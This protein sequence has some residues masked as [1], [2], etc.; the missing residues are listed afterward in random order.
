MVVSARTRARKQN[1]PFT[2][3]EGDITIPAHCPVLGLELVRGVGQAGPASPSLDKIVPALGYVRGNI[4]VISNR[5]NI[6]KRDATL[7]EIEALADWMRRQVAPASTSR[8]K[9]N[10]A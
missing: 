7:E 3:T 10:P 2:I 6:L 8:R 9:A 4:Q 5:A 1:V